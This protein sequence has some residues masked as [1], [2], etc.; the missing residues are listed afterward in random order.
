LGKVSSLKLIAMHDFHYDLKSTRKL[1]LE[2]SD[3]I[4][5]LRKSQDLQ[6]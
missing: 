4:L 6:A 5:V 3:I 2:Y 1:D